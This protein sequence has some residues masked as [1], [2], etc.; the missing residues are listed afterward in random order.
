MS[1]LLRERMGVFKNRTGCRKK[2][3]NF[4]AQVSLPGV[5]MT[6]E[7]ITIN[8]IAKSVQDISDPSTCVP[9]MYERC[10]IRGLR[11]IP[12]I[13]LIPGVGRGRCI[14][15]EVLAEKI[16]VN[17]QSSSSSSEMSFVQSLTSS[18]KD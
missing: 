15:G 7:N 17:F 1:A 14:T 6:N 2:E 12:I 16:N 3:M 8:D 5:C 10:G 9:D 11:S 4:P 13:N 18:A